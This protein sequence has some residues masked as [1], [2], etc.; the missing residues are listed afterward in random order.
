MFDVAARTSVA[1]DY[2]SSN[3]HI[4]SAD[5]SIWRGVA[6]AILT[7]VMALS[8]Q[9]SAGAAD[10]KNVTVISAHSAADG[11]STITRETVEEC[12]VSLPAAD[13]LEALT[14]A[15]SQYIRKLNGDPD[16]NQHMKVYRA[17]VTVHYLE[18]QKELV[19]ITTNAIPAQKPVVKEVEKTVR[20]SAVIESDPAEG[21]IFSAMSPRTWYF[22]SA[23]AAAQNAKERAAVWLAQHRHA[24]CPQ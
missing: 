6:V 1:A 15:E 9:D 13:E 12:I 4:R 14:S 18:R 8:A 7:A 24:L 10:H 17:T 2:R 5:M 16:K 23:E 22:S 3:T 19:I 21:D 11:E 20:R